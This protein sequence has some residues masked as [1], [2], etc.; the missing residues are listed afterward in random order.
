M[1]WARGIPTKRGSSQLM[2][3]SATKPRQLKALENTA[4][5]GR[6]TKVASEHQPEPRGLPIDRGDDGLRHGKKPR[7]GPLMALG[8][9]GSNGPGRRPVR[10]ESGRMA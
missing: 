5:F 1:S 3:C 6:E 8:S 7:V 2:P 9:I 4:F 10:P